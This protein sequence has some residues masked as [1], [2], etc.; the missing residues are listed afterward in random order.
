M[1]VKIA[2]PFESRRLDGGTKNDWTKRREFWS[3]KREQS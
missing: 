2:E 3:Y 1:N